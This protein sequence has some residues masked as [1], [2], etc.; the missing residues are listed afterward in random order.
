MLKL[1]GIFSVVSFLLPMQRIFK[2]GGI[3]NIILTPD[4]ELNIL[5][6]IDCLPKSLHKKSYALQK[7]VRFFGPPC[8]VRI[9]LYR[10][11]HLFAVLWWL[12]DESDWWKLTQL[13]ATGITV[14][15]HGCEAF[16]HSSGERVRE[17]KSCIRAQRV[18]YFRTYR[19]YKL[20]VRPI[21]KACRRGVRLVYDHQPALRLYRLKMDFIC[22]K[23]NRRRK[24]AILKCCC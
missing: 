19:E 3:Q 9:A 16:I 2:Y 7:M 15:I 10:N 6:Y 17:A 1:I 24:S 18:V 8:T 4:K 20:C 5:I 21:N 23:T 22:S 14:I 11:E 13:E 12:C